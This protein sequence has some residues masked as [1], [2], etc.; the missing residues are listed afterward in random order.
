MSSEFILNERI[1]LEEELES[2]KAPID[3]DL[4]EDDSDQDYQF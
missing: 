3:F 2:V 1:R 4:D